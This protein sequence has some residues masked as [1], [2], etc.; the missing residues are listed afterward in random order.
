MSESP[1]IRTSK[2]FFNEAEKLR[3]EAM[4]EGIDLNYPKITDA[5]F[6]DLKNLRLTFKKKT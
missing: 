2:R 3:H 6:N 4:L 1:K 5:L